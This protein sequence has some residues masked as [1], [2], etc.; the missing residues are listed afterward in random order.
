VRVLYVEDNPADLDLAQ[1]ALQRSGYDCEV[2]GAGSL[3]EARALL[4]AAP[5][6]DALLLDL[7]LPDGDGTE[8]LAEIRER[9]LPLTVVMLTGSG[10]TASALAALKGGADDYL[11]KRDDYLDRLPPLLDAALRRHHERARQQH[12][13]MRVLYVE[14][15]RTDM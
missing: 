3:D 1:R 8:L 14:H 13:P 15:D 7:R 5:G 12:R 9:Q 11:V 2:V 6:F 10:D 4:A